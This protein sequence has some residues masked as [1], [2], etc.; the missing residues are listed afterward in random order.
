MNKKYSDLPP[1]NDPNYARLWRQ[2]KQDPKKRAS[3]A[4]QY[5]QAN[6]KILSQKDKERHQRNPKIYH[7]TRWRQLGITNVLYK[8]DISLLRRAIR[9]LESQ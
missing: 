3:Y 8:D 4:K 5:Y 1:R 9:Y 7:E 6:K 2:T